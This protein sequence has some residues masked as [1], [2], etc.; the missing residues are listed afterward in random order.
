MGHNSTLY[1][2]YGIASPDSS[3]L[4]V[5]FTDKDLLGNKTAIDQVLTNTSNPYL[6][7]LVAGAQQSQREIDLFEIESFSSVDDAREAVLYWRRQLQSLGLRLMVNEGL[8]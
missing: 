2:V 4:Y 6:R 3:L 5:D 1:C 7:Q 8:A